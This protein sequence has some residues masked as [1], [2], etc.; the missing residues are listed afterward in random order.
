M[1]VTARYLIQSALKLLKV[2]DP[3]ETMEPEDAADGLSALNDMV[4]AWAL[5]SLYV[6][7]TQKVS[8]TFSGQSATIGTGGTFNTTRPVRINHAFFRRNDEDRELHVVDA[9]HYDAIA[10]K[11]LANEF[12]ALMA[13]GAKKHQA[14][15]AD[16]FELIV[17]GIKD[18][19]DLARQVSI[20]DDL[21]AQ[22]VA[23]IVIAPADSKAL[24]SA[25]KRAQEAGIVVVA[26]VATRSLCPEAHPEPD[27]GQ[28]FRGF[29]DASL[30][31]RELA[32]SRR[33]STS[34]LIEALA[35]SG[36]ALG[37]S[38]GGCRRST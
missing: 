10:L 35:G 25:C 21:I 4:D 29:R 36:L 8:A 17:N 15:H 9:D 13:E 27:P 26:A 31:A 11:S 30:G 37:P 5:D 34:S 2:I 14:A 19:R 3:L 33:S 32:P 6:L 18:E 24:V 16:E 1:T 28:V 20:V 7:A 23:A 22:R 12:F 38:L